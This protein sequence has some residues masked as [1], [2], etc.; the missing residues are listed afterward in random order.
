MIE[1]WLLNY[2]SEQ[3]YESGLLMSQTK[4]QTS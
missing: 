2:V 1:Y 3:E 4:N